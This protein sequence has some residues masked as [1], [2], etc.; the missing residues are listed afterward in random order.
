M[1]AD[2]QVFGDG[3]ARFPMRLRT[4]LIVSI[5]L[6]AATF[7]TC[8]SAFSAPPIVVIPIRSAPSIT[9]PAAN[10]RVSSPL[11]VRGTAGKN[12]KVEVNVKATYT[13]GEQDLGTFQTTA[14][15]D[16]KWNTTPI[17]L[18]L[19]EGA[20]NA[21]YTISAVQFV[22]DRAS[23]PRT[24]TVLPPLNIIYRPI[25]NLHLAI[26]GPRI[27]APA[28]NARVGSPL[29]ISGTG[30]KNSSVDV[31]VVAHYTATAG[32][33]KIARQQDLGTFRA[34]TGN[35]GK[36]KTSPVNLWLP[37][38]AKNARFEIKATQKI[39]SRN[40]TSNVIK[41]LPPLNIK[42]IPI[43]PSLFRPA[44]TITSPTDNARV[45]SPLT[46]KGTAGKGNQVEVTVKSTFTGGEQH[47]GT[48]TVRANSSGKW[49]TTPI[50]L[51]AP[52]G[53]RNIK[54]V[55]S[56]LQ[57]TDGK[58]SLSTSI[59]LSP[60]GI[61]VPMP[62]PQIV[63]VPQVTQ[64]HSNA[65]VNSPFSVRGTGITGDKVRVNVIASWKERVGFTTKSGHRDLGTHTV[66]VDTHGKWQTPHFTLNTSGRAYDIQYTIQAVQLSGSKTS[67]ATTVNAKGN[68]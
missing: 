43:N 40:Y 9:S 28:D 53:A 11:T 44:P 16:G 59:Q 46:I 35:D 23:T 15:N 21:K 54:Y 34:N 52:S 24:V 48:F 13:G 39:G 10:A 33:H 42:L 25:G 67:A 29:T 50:N 55:V 30:S 1:H 14:N 22:N 64:P 32:T 31:N 41:V 20:K 38:N 8:T 4:K 65:K 45:R 58:K 61:I 6:L 19:P 2:G 49:Q 62:M 3:I 37:E 26:L 63:P 51:S 7:G 57:M 68:E 17:N 60:L 12:H 56:A 18:W 27:T 47:L 36:W 5:P 66:N